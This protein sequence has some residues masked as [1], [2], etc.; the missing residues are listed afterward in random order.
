MLDAGG[1]VVHVMTEAARENWGLEG[2]WEGV[3]RESVRNAK[4]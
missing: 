2:L 1:V 4:E 3:R